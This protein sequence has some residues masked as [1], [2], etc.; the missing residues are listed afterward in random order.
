MCF[1]SQGCS[2]FTA[3]WAQCSYYSIFCHAPPLSALQKSFLKRQCFYFSVDWAKV[4]W[5]IFF[6]QDSVCKYMC[7]EYEDIKT[8]SV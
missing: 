1:C 5:A 7:V 3:Q 6:T 2:S 4:V 8:Q